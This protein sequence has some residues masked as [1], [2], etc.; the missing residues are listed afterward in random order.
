MKYCAK[1]GQEVNDAAVVCVHCG[2]QIEQRAEMPAQGAQSTEVDAPNTGMTVLGF[3]LP[4][5]GLILY[6]VWKND[7]PL[8]AKSALKGAIIG[9]CVSVGFSI[10]MFIASFAL[11][12]AA[13]MFSEF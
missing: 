4:I 6:L 10:I 1:C 9:F 12:S 11:G 2:C 7:T 3:F 13:F 5:V 8:K